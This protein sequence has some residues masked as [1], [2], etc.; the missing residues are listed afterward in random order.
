MEHIDQTNIKKRKGTGKVFTEPYNPS[1]IDRLKCIVRDFYKQGKK[2]RYCILVDGE[3]VVTINSDS[4]NFDGYKRYMMADT[5][6]IEVRMYFGDSP[7]CNRH[8]F[9]TQ[10][11]GLNGI[12]HEDIEQRIQEALHKQRV[13][14]ELES[15]RKKVKEKNKK[16]KEYEELLE[17]LDGKQVN[18]K[19]ILKEG[20]ELFGKYNGQKSPAPESSQVKGA[21]QTEVEVH[22]EDDT[23]QTKSDERYQA[24]KQEYNE[25]Q[26][27]KA[28]DTWEI[29]TAYPDLQ[30]EF[31]EL[32]NQ[33]IK[34]HGK[35]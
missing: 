26:M 3:M 33:K 4:R 20:I 5:H 8:I 23:E 18:F 27:D 15:L 12:G 22:A 31:S 14:T 19:D 13:E 30:K 32:V 7:N 9:Q 16:L 1:R 35:A 21:P 25:D 2:K 10:N 28:L 34:N 29:F 17:E 24:M 6:N 11:S